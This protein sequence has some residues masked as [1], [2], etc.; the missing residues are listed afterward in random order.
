[1]SFNF[2]NEACFIYFESGETKINA[3]YE[4]QSV[5]S[6]NAVLL[7]CG[8]YF[9]ELLPMIGQDVYEILV[10][11]LPKEIIRKIYTNEFPDIPTSADKDFI[12]KVGSS[13]I[14]TEYIKGLQF[15]F[16]NPTI[17]NEELLDLKIRELILLL[18]QTQNVATIQELLADTFSSVE[19]NIKEVVSSHIFTDCSITDLAELCNQSPSTF[20]RNFKKI[21]NDTPSNYIKTKRLEKAK[22]LLQHTNSTISEVAIETGFYDTPHFSKSFKEKYGST[23]N[24]YRALM[25]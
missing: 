12:Y 21:F 13:S 24:E 9:S 18:I 20:K 6:K 22:Y 5:E 17:V 14:L 8:T 23:P 1:M 3:P 15:Y 11:H 19:V 4:Q 2:P 25:K 10:F 7:R 16:N